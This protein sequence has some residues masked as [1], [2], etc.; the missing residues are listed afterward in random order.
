MDMDKG[1]SISSMLVE[2]ASFQES[3]I[4]F[5]SSLKIERLLVSLAS[6]V[7]SPQRGLYVNRKTLR[8]ISST[9]VEI[10]L[11]SFKGESIV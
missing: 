3:P 5:Y 10:T 6:A 4:N 1:T 8:K 2:I 11:E 7:F 9:A